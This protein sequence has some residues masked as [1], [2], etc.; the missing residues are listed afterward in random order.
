MPGKPQ[1]PSSIVTAWTLRCAPQQTADDSIRDTGY[2][3]DR[4]V[5]SLRAWTSAPAP[6]RA[7]RGN[8]LQRYG[9][10]QYQ[11]RSEPVSPVSPSPCLRVNGSLHR[12]GSNSLGGF[13][14]VS[15]RH[16]PPR[17]AGALLVHACPQRRFPTGRDPRVQTGTCTSAPAKRRRAREDG[18]PVPCAASPLPPSA[19]PWRPPASSPPAR[20]SA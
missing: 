3:I 10:T 8:R 1:Q 20:R 16:E 5:I 11:P 18:A 15:L 13:A 7:W 17:R 14:P 6:A 2:G 4:R 12:S 9:T 19:P